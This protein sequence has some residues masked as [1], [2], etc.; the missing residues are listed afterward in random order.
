MQSGC[1][2]VDATNLNGVCGGGGVGGRWL[3]AL[4]IVR[5]TAVGRLTK[6]RSV[7][8]VI[9]LNLPVPTKLHHV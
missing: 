9:N 6:F 5:S 1:N 7:K 3:F 8:V 2:A 4:D